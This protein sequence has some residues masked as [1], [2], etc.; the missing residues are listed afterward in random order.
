MSHTF[1][2]ANNWQPSTTFSQGGSHESADAN[3]RKSDK[4]LLP[5]PPLGLFEDVPDEQPAPSAAATPDARPES[6]PEG[7]DAR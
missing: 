5:R 1:P 6:A 7:D 4:A 2:S 3:V